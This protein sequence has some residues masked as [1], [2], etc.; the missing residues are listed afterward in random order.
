MTQEAT[1]T[2][3]R[4]EPIDLLI[5]YERRLAE[6]GAALPAQREIRDR[7]TGIGFRVGDHRLM[8]SM[9]EV[10]EILDPPTCTR[11]PGTVSWFLGIANVRGNLV[12]V[13]DLHGFLA[14]GRVAQ[15]R[16]SRV[17][18]YQQEGLHAA[19]RVDDVL[20]MKRFGLDQRARVETDAKALAPYVMDGFRQGD[21][22]WPVLSLSDFVASRDFLGISR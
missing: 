21:E 1:E 22:A 16:Q 11:V 3:V 12:P 8:A 20:G 14:G 9:D 7:W 5:G 10:R 2:G 6:A 18:T 15:S 17:L 4:R 13:F 19:F